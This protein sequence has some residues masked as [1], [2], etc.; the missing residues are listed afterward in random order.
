MTSQRFA[1]SDAARLDGRLDR[2]LGV[3]MTK[4]CLPN[5]RAR[6]GCRG[7]ALLLITWRAWDATFAKGRQAPLREV[8]EKEGLAK[9]VK[10]E[11]LNHETSLSREGKKLLTA[12]ALAGNR[13]DWME[14]R[15]KFNTYT[16]TETP[17][18]NAVMHIALNCSK[19]QEGARAYERLCD[20]NLTKTSPTISAALK[21]Y[22]RL[23]QNQTVREIWDEAKSSMKIDELMAAARIEAAAAEGDVETAATVLDDM[24]RSAVEID[25]LHVTSA[26]RACWEAPGRRHSAAKCLYQL[27]LDRGLTPNIVTF[28][29]LMGAYATAPLHDS[30]AVLRE[31]TKYGVIPNPVFAETYLTSILMVVKAEAIKLRTGQKFADYLRQREPERLKAARDALAE[32]RAAGIYLSGLS[33]CIDEALQ[34]LAAEA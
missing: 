19:V 34:L 27:L 15:K 22:S 10:A 4:P 23:G 29:C 20:S 13:G 3:R 11:R 21:I 28:T 25:A 30:V 24:S 2:T 7:L 32:F 14:V 6:F 8:R 1:G 5:H 9:S 17:I 16:G 12:I 31:M 18:Y 33:L 26:I